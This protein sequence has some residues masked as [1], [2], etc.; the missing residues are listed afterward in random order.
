MSITI[1]DRGFGVTCVVWKFNTN[2]RSH[3]K[4]T[5]LLKNIPNYTSS[6][7]MSYTSLDHYRL[8]FCTTHR[9]SFCLK[10]LNGGPVQTKNLVDTEQES[11]IPD[12]YRQPHAVWVTVDGGQFKANSKVFLS[13]ERKT[14]D[15]NVSAT[16]N[17]LPVYF[18][19]TI[20]QFAFKFFIHFNSFG[21]GELKAVQH[22]TDYLFL[23]QRHCDVHFCFPLGKKIG[24][25]VSILAAAS[26]VFAAMFKHDMKESNTGVVVVKDIERD[27]F[28]ELLHYIYSGRTS[29]SMTEAIAQALFAAADKYNVNE[30][31]NECAGF[32]LARVTEATAQKMFEVASRHFIEDLRKECIHLL[33]PHIQMKNVIPLIIW[34]HLNHAVR[35]KEAALNF[36]K[37]NFQAVCESRDYEKMMFDYPNL[38][39][40]ATRFM[41][42]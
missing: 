30:L 42:R 31:K 2:S 29:V 20:K 17:T 21:I 36:A 6:F 37:K 25:H 4:E 27:A 7:E 41:S 23:Q 8:D 40:E 15:A 11:A 19:P 18:T 24:G 28:Y 33:I 3:E 22:L 34:A 26:P 32:L 1:E 12:H 9:L 35:I 14:L 5:F 39:L 38:C 13:K 16:W 10:E